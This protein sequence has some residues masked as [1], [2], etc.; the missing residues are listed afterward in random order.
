[1]AQLALGARGG[2][3]AEA[4]SVA[5]GAPP[6]RVTP[7]SDALAC[8]LP[9]SGVPASC[10]ADVSSSRSQ[11]RQGASHTCAAA[12]ASQR[13]GSV[14]SSKVNTSSKVSPPSSVVHT[15]STLGSMLA[16]TQSLP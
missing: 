1:S 2:D 14:T 8:A 5:G 4:S 16:H 3:G 13:T 6:S 11:S 12:G 10:A 15:P 7:P 9:A